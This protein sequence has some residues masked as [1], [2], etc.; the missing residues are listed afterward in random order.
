M[1]MLPD[2]DWQSIYE[3]QPQTDGAYLVDDFYVPAL[4]RSIRYDRIAGYFSSSALAVASQG[5]DALLDDDGQMRLVVGTELYSTDRPVF[6][7]LTDEL[8]ESLDEL[9]DEQLDAQLQLLARLLREDQLHIKVAV[10]REGSWR[11][12]HPKM[13]IFHDDA[14]NAL[15]FEGSVNETVGGWKNNYE[16]FKVHRSWIDQQ[17]TY[18]D[19]DI[20]TFDRLWENEHP[21]VEVYDLPDAIE[22]ELIDWKDPDSQTELEEAL[23]IARGEAPPTERDKANIVADGH[24]APGGLALA[25]EG[26]TITPWPHQRVVS[27][28]LV[29]T[30]PNS[31]LLCDE[32]GLGKT[33]EAGLTLSRLGLTNEL[34][35]GLLLVPA[36][37]TVQWQEEMWE[38]FNLNTYRYERG[39]DYEYA[40]IDAFGREHSPP[41]AANLDLGS[42]E[43]DQ[44]WVESPIWRF[45]HEHHDDDATDGPVIV[46]M[47]WHTARLEDRWNQVAPKDGGTVRTRDD[48]PVS[49]RGRS[50]SDREGVW[51]AVIVDEAHNGRKGSSFYSL[52]ERLRDHTQ[53]Y[54]LLT[55]TPMQLHAGELYDLMSL[56]DLPGEWDNQDNFVEFFETR[57]ALTKALEETL[58]DTDSSHA[59]ESWSSQATL[60]EGRYQDRLTGDRTL[61]DRVFDAVASELDVGDDQ[62]ARSIGK[63]RVLRACDLA[64]DYGEHYDG[65]VDSFDAAM[66]EHGID[67]FD[68]KEDEKLKYLLYPEWKANDEWL[69][70]SRNERLAALDELTTS[71]WQVVRNV[72]AESTPV[73]A[74][75]HR[76][77]RDTLRKY[78]RVGLLDATVPDRD[79]EQQKIEL[80]DA[81]R[82]VYD[83][84]DEYTR[85]F[86]KLAQ[87]SDEAD[88]QAIGFVMTTYRQRLTSSV[89][90]ISQSLQNRLRKLRNQRTV[91]KG[92]QRAADSE[93]DDAEQAILETLSEYDLEDMEEVDELEGD[94]EDTDLAEIVPNVTDDGIHLLE[95]E[96]EELESFV[97]ELTEIDQDPKIG[98]LIDD[99]DEL[100]REGHN[101]AI[102]FTQYTDTMDFI[103]ESLVSIHGE[104][105][106]TYSG[107]G[108][109]VYDSE[110]G[111]WSQ[112][113]KERVKREFAAD[114]GQVDIL[115]CTDSAS[116]GLNLQECGALINYDLPWNPMRVEQRIGRIDRIGQNYDEVTILNYSYEDTVETDI[117]DR[118]DD[119]IGL[120]ENV[121]GEM[122]PILSGVSDQIRSATLETE[123]GDNAQAVDDAEREFSEE[124]ENQEDSD[125]VDV[126]ESLDTVETPVAQD[127]IDEAKLDAWESA[128]HP[129]IVEVGDDQY[130]Y[131]SPFVTD[132]VEELLV[133]NEALADAGI[134]LTPIG[135][136]DLSVT[137]TEFADEF[138]FEQTTYR[139]EAESDLPDFEGEQT[140]AQAIAPDGHEIAVTFSAECTDEFPSIHYLAPGNP[141]FGRFVQA[142]LEESDESAR[143][144]K[145][146]APTDNS[147]SQSV[148][149]AWE[150]DGHLTTLNEEG[151]VETH[152]VGGLSQWCETF[153][154]NRSQNSGSS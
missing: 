148:V 67:P 18:V 75:I 70:F 74:L 41:A 8:T 12:F 25:E 149:C 69:T 59:D 111:T 47:S 44:A 60:T 46:I 139:L 103:R 123:R 88:S 13:G 120:F 38:K 16:R 58:G 85:K 23:Q 87:Q 112:V 126:G 45:L 51:D 10:P 80:T 20:E 117:Y 96:I 153:L 28:T 97:D 4:E 94:I 115:V 66:D 116:E 105:V 136:L 89:Y 132:A 63:E 81:T 27:D 113:G 107:R 79:P 118:L 137:D 71:G 22:E 141:L 37:L 76:N 138:R 53:T 114:D 82:R 130:E 91:L 56:L 7:A 127:V 144:S 150:R 92:K 121:V 48:V 108:G 78:E 93:Y 57:R 140:L 106:A 32:V 39:S 9:D 17:S 72:L 102:V 133:G 109:E 3:S 54:Y 50:T 14:G 98:Q 122:Q 146:V 124:I 151:V 36:S 99:L 128:D 15:S 101:R 64:S 31:F 129:D 24:L 119:R 61:S 19:D 104:T 2:W 29:N 95:Q 40:F 147:D 100:D 145:R 62:H 73:D 49:C 34:E 125:R 68:A 35:T 90:A 110:S 6:E 5:I 143:L 142:L 83:H 77:T 21:Y 26:S 30:Y 134:T 154:E 65:Y 1:S 11:I 86:Y 152:S 43:R 55:A 135:E 131:P 33:I 52:L 42:D 84:I